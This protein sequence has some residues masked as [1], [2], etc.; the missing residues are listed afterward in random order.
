MRKLLPW[1]LAV[2]LAI[3]PALSQVTISPSAA[4]PTVTVLTSGTAQT[5]TTPPGAKYIFVRMVGGGGGGAP[6]GTSPGASANGTATTFGTLSAGG[7][8]LSNGQNAGIGGTTSGCDVNLSGGVGGQTSGLA[9][10]SIGGV[11][12]GTAFGGGGTG[13]IT[14]TAGAGTTNTGSGGG[15]AGA[16]GATGGAGAG[17][18][19]YCE[20]TF[21]GPAATFTYTVGP[22]GAGGTLGTGGGAGGNGATGI[23]IVMEYYN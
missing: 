10:N 13:S 15:G 20:K 17:A 14:G 19:G 22:G 8:A 23:I 16:T 6:S 21:L 5:Y 4:R 2:A 3:Y 9:V 12:A 18:G 1:L 7:G 11:G